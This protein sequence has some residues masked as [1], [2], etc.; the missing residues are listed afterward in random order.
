M[1]TVTHGITDLARDTMLSRL[2]TRRGSPP[3]NPTSLTP[4][5]P[6]APIA[7]RI[8]SVDVTEL[9]CDQISQYE[10]RELHCVVTPMIAISGTASNFSRP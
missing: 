9:G 3:V 6:A 5:S 4:I 7:A 10:Q 1:L 2:S 8:V